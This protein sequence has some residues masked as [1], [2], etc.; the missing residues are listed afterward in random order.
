MIKLSQFALIIFFSM[1]GIASTQ[2]AP[3]N[4]YGTQPEFQ[5][6]KKLEKSPR[7]IAIERAVDDIKNADEEKRR[8]LIKEYTRRTKA[9]LQKGNN[10]E[11]RFYDEILTRSKNQ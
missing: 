11:A 6:A 2:A 9:A 1:A 4:K 7:D 3:L 8:E 5:P 10:D